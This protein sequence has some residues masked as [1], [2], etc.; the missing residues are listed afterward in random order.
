LWLLAALGIDFY[1][2]VI[3][4]AQGGWYGYRYLIASAIPLFALPVALLIK[5]VEKTIRQKLTLCWMLLAVPPALSMVCFEGNDTDLNLYNSMQDFG[6]SDISNNLYQFH[7]WQTVL[8]KPQEFFGIITKGGVEYFHFILVHLFQK[9]GFFP[10][11]FFRLYSVFDGVVFIKAILI[12]ALPFAIAFLFF[13]RFK[14]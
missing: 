6:I 13:R 14:F 12:Y 5:N 7:V 3:W 10:N 9:M 8:F 4:G 11:V 2:T 1:I